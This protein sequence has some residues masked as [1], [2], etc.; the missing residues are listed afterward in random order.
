MS[1]FRLKFLSGKRKQLRIFHRF[2][3]KKKGLQKRRNP[4]GETLCQDWTVNTRERFSKKKVALMPLEKRKEM[5][6]VEEKIS[7]NKQCKLLKINR[8]C[9][10]YQPKSEVE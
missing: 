9:F 3:T 8:N 10:Y 7:V 5:F 2:L 1:C 6:D 4:C